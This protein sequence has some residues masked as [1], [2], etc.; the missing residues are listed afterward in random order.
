MN[1]T[2]QAQT[3]V[4]AENAMTP[5]PTANEA[6][7]NVQLQKWVDF[8]ELIA[9]EI[10]PLHQDKEV[11]PFIREAE[12]RKK[13]RADKRLHGRLR[14]LEIEQ[15]AILLAE[16]QKNLAEARREFES[17]PQV[18]YDYTPGPPSCIE[19]F[20]RDEKE[21]NR[22]IALE[23]EQKEELL[24]EVMEKRAR[25]LG[26]EWPRIQEMSQDIRFDHIPKLWPGYRGLI[27]NYFHDHPLIPPQKSNERFFEKVGVWC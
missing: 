1:M 10:G 19:D 22:L 6:V 14:K 25:E 21:R 18:P 3:N 7:I 23:R 16:S 17:Q 11:A 4:M 12:E 9:S 8:I 26:D 13:M 5:P 27:R 2:E 20:F 24:R 15:K